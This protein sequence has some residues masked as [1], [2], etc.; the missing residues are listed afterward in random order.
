M[1]ELSIA[2]EIISIVRR[3]LTTENNSNVKTIRIKIGKLSNILPES[4]LFCF[5][6]SVEG[7]ELEGAKLEMKY[8]PVTISCAEC[9]ENSNSEDYIFACPVC[10]SS[11]IKVLSGDE[12][13]IQEIEI[14]N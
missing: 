7:T 3:Y 12:L 2:E 1:H 13:Q 9:G 5:N 8:I 6:A 4:L 11:K 10:G 14:N